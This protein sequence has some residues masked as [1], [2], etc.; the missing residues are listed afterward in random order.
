MIIVEE[1]YRNLRSAIYYPDLWSNMKPN[2]KW[3]GGRE[4]KPSQ[5]TLI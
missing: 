4:R 2:Q 1:M 3:H 5:E